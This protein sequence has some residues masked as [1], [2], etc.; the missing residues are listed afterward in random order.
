MKQE[1]LT[2]FEKQLKEYNNFVPGEDMG[3]DYLY[4]R[5]KKMDKDDAVMEW[6]QRKINEIVLEY[7]ARLDLDDP[8]YRNEAK[9]WILKALKN[10]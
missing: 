7:C 6:F 5:E 10:V 9:D 1:R 2:I 8:V 3:I 4:E